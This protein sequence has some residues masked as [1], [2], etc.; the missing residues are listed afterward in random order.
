MATWRRTVQTVVIVIPALFPSPEYSGP[1]P[2]PP[3]PEVAG[4]AGELSP[5]VTPGIKT[6]SPK[7]AW[8]RQ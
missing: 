3:L 4:E 5:A 7:P 1:Q 6:D 2:E 8:D